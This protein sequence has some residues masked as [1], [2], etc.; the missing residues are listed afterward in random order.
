MCERVKMSPGSWLS[1][2][3][4]SI[5][6]FVWLLSTRDHGWLLK[7]PFL[8]SP[9][10][11]K[12]RTCW[13]LWSTFPRRPKAGWPVARG[14]QMRWV[15]DVEED[16]ITWPVEWYQDWKRLKRLATLRRTDYEKMI[17]KCSLQRRQERPKTWS[18]RASWTKP[19]AIWSCSSWPR[20]R[21][22]VRR[23]YKSSQATSRLSFGEPRQDQDVLEP[24]F[25]WMP[26]MENI[27]KP[28]CN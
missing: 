20:P 25:G 26:A 24:P 18:S 28:I 16:F 11:D 21:R 23:S 3:L 9:D 6:L 22:H 13:A 15:W 4:F 5:V 19:L 12:L 2:V 8:S 17:D 1:V 10:F 27:A 14:Q 7:P